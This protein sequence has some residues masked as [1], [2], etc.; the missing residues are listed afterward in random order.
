M[1]IYKRG[2]KYWVRFVHHGVT[3]RKSLGVTDKHSAELLAGELRRKVERRSCGLLTPLDEHRA[4]PIG[5]HVAA[6]LASVAAKGVG[7]KYHAHVGA[8]LAELV[9]HANAK[10]LADLNADKLT[11]L[12]GELR[13]RGLSARSLNDRV[14]IASS[15]GLW[16][17]RTGRASTS[18]F[19][20]ITGY[21]E[22]SDRRRVRRALTPDEA[23]RLLESAR[24][25]PMAT[26]SGSRGKQGSAS[27][28]E[29]GAT[30]AAIYQV[31][32]GTGLRCGELRK[33]T[34]ACVDLD[35]ALLTVEAPT[36][37]S[38]HEQT[39]PLRSELVAMLRA[40]KEAAG[41][42]PGDRVFPRSFPTLRAFERDL[43]HANIPQVDDR[44]RVVDLHALR[45]TFISWLSASGVHPRVAQALARHAN[46]NQTMKTYTD[47]SVLDLRGA[48]E[49]LPGCAQK[50]AQSPDGTTDKQA[51]TS[52]ERETEKPNKGKSLSAAKPRVSLVPGPSNPTAV[53]QIHGC[54]EHNVGTPT[55]A[56]IYRASAPFATSTVP[57]FETRYPAATILS[58][59]EH[60]E[61]AE[62][63]ALLKAALALAPVGT[64]ATLIRVALAAPEEA[65]AIIQ[66][67]LSLLAH[68]HHADMPVAR[69]A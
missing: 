25:R 29:L 3:T 60:A 65:H 66:G 58:R 33:L 41:A 61:P 53:H 42:S 15:F 49:S 44:G 5:E 10:L 26:F 69:E 54:V 64:V 27:L 6:F 40:R 1:N 50:C 22:D 8:V 7:S 46:I 59:A 48:L 52:T 21:N 67:A 38:R 13:A 57:T 43:E 47:L 51:V 62:R 68:A 14:T 17:V 56:N 28:A 63:V 35:R 32:L 30:R 2:R 24:K 39:V 55:R 31:L 37:K 18:P 12:L 11:A 16:C 9:N 23:T 45:T 20:G 36:A 34:W 19:L 4:L